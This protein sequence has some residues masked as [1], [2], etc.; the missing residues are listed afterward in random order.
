MRNFAIQS[1]VFILVLGCQMVF[2]QSTKKVLREQ[3]Y[4]LWHTLEDESMAPNGN[5]IA[6][7]LQYENANDTLVLRA[8]KGDKQFIFPQYFNGQFSFD[9][10]WF[11]CQNDRDEV[12]LFDLEKETKDEFK[13]VKKYQLDA[14]GNRIGILTHTDTLLLQQVKTKKRQYLSNVKAFEFSSKGDIVVVKDT[15]VVLFTTDN[16]L[17]AIIIAHN[18]LGFK[19]VIWNQDKGVAFFENQETVA[20]A[21]Q[22]HAIGYYDIATQKLYTL[23]TD[24]FPELR[25]KSIVKPF[26]QKGMLLE[27]H[28]DKVFFYLNAREKA[29]RE[30][31]KMEVWEY[32]SPLEYP[33][34]I[35]E[36]AF[37]TQNKLAVWWPQK[38]KIRVLA[39]NDRPR[40]IVCPDSNYII[41]FN[42]IAY[43]PQFELSGPV[44]LYLTDLK[45]NETVLLLKKQSQKVQTF[46]ASSQG[47]Y[48]H[49]YRDQNWW[50]YD[51]HK[52]TH[53]NITKKLPY[54]V[55][56]YKQDEAGPKYAFGCAGWS[57]DNR[58]VFI[59]DEYDIWKIT[60]DGK[61]RT[62]ITNGRA[63]A[64]K[65]RVE[66]DLYVSQS[67][68]GSIEFL[69]HTFDKREGIIVSAF[70]KNK[71]WGYY[72]WSETKGLKKVHH[73]TS[74]SSK[75][76]TTA[77]NQEMIWIEE[78]CNVPPRI[79]WQSNRDKNSKVIYQSN[80]Q[81][82]RFESRK[83]ELIHYVNT[84]GDSL[85][86][87]LYYPVGYDEAKKYPMITYIY[88]KL[89]HRL[90]QYEYP[91]LY[92]RG[93][94]AV[95]NYIHDGYFVLLPDIVYEVG[96][97]GI[98]AKDCVVSAVNEVLKR[99]VVD[100]NRIG[101]YGHSFGGYQ[102]ASIITQTD[103][104][105]AAVVGSGVTDLNN[106]YVQ[107]NWS[108]NRTQAW[109]FE[110][111]QMRMG[112][113]PFENSEGYKNN[114]PIA[115]VTKISTPVL[116][117]T[118]KE[119]YNVDWNQ[120]IYLH[121][122]LRRLQKKNRLLLFPKEGH[123]INSPE[124]Q[125][126]L[127]HEIKKWFEVHLKQ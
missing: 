73:N 97:P 86:G 114:S 79:V 89:S 5:W 39:T 83:A 81:Y 46:G 13:K 70:D 24:D 48:L 99:K 101:L 96:N 64:T 65:F 9:S 77:K 57:S 75:I 116:I 26:G 19:N 40:T 41:S 63:T 119:D 107:M 85:Q 53:T 82:D 103:L 14:S 67:F 34:Q 22:N 87:V 1:I 31:V 61:E 127:T 37:E 17:V 84:R 102:V 120:S 100:E 42:P 121:M 44:D 95:A 94:F 110:S 55:E 108:W 109:R 7:K 126:L 72:F 125:V 25:D 54:T 35:T 52:K 115:N 8:S 11:S 106:L 80:K 15:S 30:E 50:V 2:G 49:Y 112:S 33:S 118:G 71:N 88:E 6:F 74:K 45:T 29:K 58:H 12:V 62:R 104:F 60:P 78:A 20:T 66:D 23:N 59:Y 123:T 38:N 91:T 98:A 90:H 113:N 93:G 16:P 69:T 92:N 43:E 18:S 3:D 47:S 27:P 51:M 111:Q 32:D 68:R 21:N 122:A 28:E 10:N 4:K 56:N 117:W 76:K 105:K 36:G 124:N